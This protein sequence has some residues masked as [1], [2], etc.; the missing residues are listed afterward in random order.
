[1]AGEDEESEDPRAF[2]NQAAWKRTLILV[3][4]SFMNFLLGLVI[5]VILYS[6]AYAFRSTELVDFRPV[7]PTPARMPCR[8]ATASTG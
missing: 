5:V 7:A 6:G 8:R 3:A 1:M 4:G 2:T